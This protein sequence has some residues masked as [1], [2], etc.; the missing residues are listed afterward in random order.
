MK[1]HGAVEEAF[2]RYPKEDTTNPR[3]MREPIKQALGTCG[4]TQLWI[5]LA[6]VDK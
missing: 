6:M 3:L 4:G 5:Q 1:E 2:R